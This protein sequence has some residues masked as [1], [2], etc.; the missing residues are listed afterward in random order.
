MKNSL[1]LFIY[2]CSSLLSFVVLYPVLSI[3]RDIVAVPEKDF[4]GT[5]IFVS[6]LSGLLLYKIIKWVI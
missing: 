4:L 3:H 2:S 6:L 5:I 1:V